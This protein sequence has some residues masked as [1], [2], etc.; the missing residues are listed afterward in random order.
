MK[1]IYV[2]STMAFSGKTLISLA[3]GT[4][5]KEKGISF[6]YRKPV[7]NRP[8]F[9]NGVIVDEDALF[10]S[11]ALGISVPPEE[12]SAL[13]LTQDLLVQGFK[14]KTKNLFE[15]V[16]KTCREVFKTEEILLSV[17]Y[18]NLYS[19][20]FLNISGLSLA[21]A[22]KARVILV[23]RYEGE[24]IVD[25]VLKAIEDL[26][27]LKVGLVFNDLSPEDFYNY[28]DLIRP[29]FEAQGISIL[30]EIPHDDILASVSVKELKEYL[31]AKLLGNVSED[32]LVKH[33]LIGGMQVDKAIQYF[34]QTPDFGVIVGGDRSDIQLAAIETGAVCL[35]LTGGLYPNEI[36]MAHAEEAGVPILILQEDTYSVARKVEH[37]PMKTRIRHPQKLTRALELGRKYIDQEILQ[38]LLD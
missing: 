32:R 11:Q 22:L 17:G 29:F 4:Y 23:V 3:I 19:G 26:E 27:G 8:T 18:G 37:L 20:T 33:F 13:I 2:C 38:R 25:Y 12:L 9:L 28:K 7:G 5:L 14:G 16:L 30:G 15:K 10:V 34:R 6:T 21:K 1:T 31:G 35:L 36:I 24:Y